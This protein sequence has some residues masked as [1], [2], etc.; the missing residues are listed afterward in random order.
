[1]ASSKEFA[2][3]H[4]RAVNATATKDSSIISLDTLADICAA[5]SIPVVAIGGIDA[6]N[7]A[8]PVDAGCAG[9]AVVSAIFGAEDPT[10][11]AAELRAVVDTALGL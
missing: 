2:L 6:S 10:A 5:V 4:M 1:M 11:A 8:P 9:V 3:R 7:A